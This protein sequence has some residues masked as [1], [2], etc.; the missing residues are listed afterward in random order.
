MDSNITRIILHN[1]Y[2]TIYPRKT[3][4]FWYTIVR[5]LHKERGNSKNNSK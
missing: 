5:T 2:N 4:L 1:N 3:V